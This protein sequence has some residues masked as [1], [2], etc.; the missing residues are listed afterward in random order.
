MVQL[1]G[2][3]PLNKKRAGRDDTDD[4][5]LV[6]DDE[7]EMSKNIGVA[8]ALKCDRGGRALYKFDWKGNESP[9]AGRVQ[10]VRLIL[11]LLSA[12]MSNLRAQKR[13]APSLRAKNESISSHSP[14]KNVEAVPFNMATKNKVWSRVWVREKCTYHKIVAGN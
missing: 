7:T 10:S 14:R 8:D 4:V 5:I 13:R 11:S 2:L 12:K 3:H 9:R 6:S 1:F